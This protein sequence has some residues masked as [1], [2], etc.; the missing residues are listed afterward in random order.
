MNKT[1]TTEDI[2]HVL[3]SAE[4]DR[5]YQEEFNDFVVG[6]KGAPSRADIL[7]DIENLF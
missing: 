4:F 7:K 1:I 2:L 5:W 3:E 6:E